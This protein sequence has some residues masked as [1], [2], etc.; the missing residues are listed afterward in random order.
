MRIPITVKIESRRSSNDEIE[1]LET[2]AAGFLNKN[3]N[4]IQLHYTE[5]EESGMGATKTTVHLCDGVVSVNRSGNVNSHMLFEKGKTH[6]CIY[7]TGF[8]PMQLMI[9][10]KE[11]KCDLSELG[12]KL[13]V[14]YSVEI[15]G[16]SAEKTTLTL[17]VSPDS[18]VLT[19]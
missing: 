6:N 19:S 13:L 9:S 12:G 5:S 3:K 7:D 15:A 1:R 17:S 4:G 16:N 14:D 11:L 10:T 18:S 8:F 2:C